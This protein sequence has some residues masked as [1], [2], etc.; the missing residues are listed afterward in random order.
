M[1]YWITAN[2]SVLLY[3]VPLTTLGEANP[4]T[5]A[6]LDPML[7]AMLLVVPMLDTAP[8]AAKTENRPTVPK[9]KLLLIVPVGS[10]MVAVLILIA[11]LIVRIRPCNVRPAPGSL[12]A[13]LAMNDPLSVTF[14][15][16]E[17]AP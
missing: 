6:E 13:W 4:V 14:V 16:V 2:S 15:P 1:P 17:I 10:V 3:I 11:P 9:V 7:C 5:A 8:M 12:A